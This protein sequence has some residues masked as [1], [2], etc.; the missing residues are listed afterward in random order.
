MRYAIAFVAAVLAAAVA[1]L[2]FSAPI[3]SALVAGMRF[4]SPDEVATMHAMLFMAGNVA[5]LIA[6][7]LV[8]LALGIRLEKARPAL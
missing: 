6:G 8:G 7:W 2:F 4:E 1:A 3:A 5:A